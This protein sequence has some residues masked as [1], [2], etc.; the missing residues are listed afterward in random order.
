VPVEEQEAYEAVDAA[1][2]GGVRY[3]DTAPHY[4]LGLSERR[5]GVALSRRRRQ[6]FAISTK[7]GRRLITNPAPTGSDL[8]AGGFVV[9]D[10]MLRVRD[11]SRGGVRQSLEASF[12]RLRLEYVDV[13][14]VHDPDD[15][16]DEAISQ[17][18]PALV[19]LREA[20]AIKAVGVGMNSWEPLMRIVSETD[21]DVVMLAGRWTLLD[22][23]GEPLLEECLRRGVAVIAAAP[24]N[25][26]LLAH[27]WPPEGASFDYRE[28]PQAVLN[29]ARTLARI[30]QSHG[31]SL[32]HVAVSFPLRHP[33]VVSVVAGVRNS[34]E[35]RAVA[36]WVASPIPG[37]V[38]D[39]LSQASA[40][41]MC[42]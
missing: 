34:E 42:G 36:S 15:F 21:V 24:F 33:A 23:S 31:V 22:R 3:F 39:D 13:V 1:W 20:G 28:T 16:L 32:P 27:S 8:S 29:Q 40:R 2:T 18:I 11:Y 38:W 37:D 25:S 14:F 17:A 35:A 6:D 7:V 10:D 9:P 5:L 19:E 12:E 30:C 41:G 4:G 26:G